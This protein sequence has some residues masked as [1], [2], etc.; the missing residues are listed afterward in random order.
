MMLAA[1]LRSEL[2]AATEESFGH[3]SDSG[4]LLQSGRSF[5]KRP[6]L[7]KLLPSAA[8]IMAA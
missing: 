7:A 6:T 3:I 4:E 2:L 1:F 8:P 5:D